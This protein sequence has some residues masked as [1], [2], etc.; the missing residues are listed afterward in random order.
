[1]QPSNELRSLYSEVF[2][3]AKTAGAHEAR[4]S[5]SERDIAQLQT[6]MRTAT[7]SMDMTMAERP[8][9]THDL[10]TTLHLL[11]LTA[12]GALWLAPRA[13]MILAAVPGWFAAA[14][15]WVQ[16]YVAALL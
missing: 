16:T 8:A 2:Q 10:E 1:M 14:W 6:D 15:R 5:R 13:L 4:I 3:L 9:S 7:P 11:R 12:K